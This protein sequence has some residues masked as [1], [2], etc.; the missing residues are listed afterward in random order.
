MSGWRPKKRLKPGDSLAVVNPIEFD[1]PFC[2]KHATVGDPDKG[3]AGVIHALPPCP[4]FLRLEVEDY[5]KA[6][7]DKL[8]G[9]S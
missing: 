6:V 2:G 7:N 3:V 9:P 1:C 8:A 5:L 4:T